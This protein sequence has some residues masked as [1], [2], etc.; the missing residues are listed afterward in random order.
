MQHTNSKS[1]GS[2]NSSS[3][4]NSEADFQQLWG[5]WT[6]MLNGLYDDPRVTQVMNSGVG[7]YL[8]SHP[9]LALTVMLFS[10]MAAVPVGLF[11][12]FALVTIVMSAI[13]F[14]FCEV[15]L[16][17][18]AG[19]T[20]L[21]VLSGLALFSIVVAFIVNAFYFIIVTILKYYPLSKQVK[22]QE[23]F[24]GETPKPKDIQ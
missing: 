7:R 23:E 21:S 16:L 17:S 11:L 18:V 8:S 4:S 10:S 15:I 24:E 19:L 14:V 13:G 12:I 20:L 3:S 2:R 6:T 5:R 22:A 9:F 1:G